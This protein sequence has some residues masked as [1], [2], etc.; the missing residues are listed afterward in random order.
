MGLQAM[1][2]LPAEH[3]ATD[4]FC[5]AEKPTIAD[6]CLVTQVTPAKTFNCWLDPYPKGDARL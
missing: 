3:P 6:I 2:T 5:D 4:G 1:E